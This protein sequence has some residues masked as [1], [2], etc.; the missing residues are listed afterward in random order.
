[1]N[2]KAISA[3][4]AYHSKAPGFGLVDLVLVYE[5]S[6]RHEDAANTGKLLLE[7]RPNFTIDG[8][9]IT[10]FQADADR[11]RTDVAALIAAGL[12][13]VGVKPS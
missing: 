10:Q 7:L 2:E 6:G 11:L 4:K 9:T 12:P 8:W 1:M 13:T 3:F 5:Q